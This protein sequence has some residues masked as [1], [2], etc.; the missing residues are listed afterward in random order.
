MI[1]RQYDSL[2][3][4]DKSFLRDYRKFNSKVWMLD[5]KLSAILTRYKHIS[6]DFFFFSL[7]CLFSKSCEF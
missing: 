4:N 6:H 7:S 1:P 3:P 5:R 2:D